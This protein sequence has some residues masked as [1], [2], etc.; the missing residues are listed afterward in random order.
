LKICCQIFPIS[1]IGIDFVVVRYRYRCRC[2]R[3][4]QLNTA[5]EGHTLAGYRPGKKP[6][7]E[8]AFAG[9]VRAAGFSG[10]SHFTGEVIEAEVPPAPASAPVTFSSG[11]IPGFSGFGHAT[12]SMGGNPSLVGAAFT[13]AAAPATVSPA[14]PAAPVF[15]GFG[16]ATGQ[17]GG[18]PA[19]PKATAI[20]PKK[21][22]A[23][24][25]GYLG[26]I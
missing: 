1:H 13:K 4:F 16:H 15:S 12:G 2:H 9:K 14:A 8:D 25:G 18:N 20:G 21:A 24:S 6:P 7:T 11:G 22:S 5:L 3:H 10:F 26:S 17:M 23:L 19:I